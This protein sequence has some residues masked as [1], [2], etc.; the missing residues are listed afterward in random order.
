MQRSYGDEIDVDALN[1]RFGSTKFVVISYRISYEDPCGRGC[2][3]IL[4]RGG[5]DLGVAGVHG[6]ALLVDYLADRVDRDHRA[7]MSN[8]VVISF[9]DL[10]DELGYGTWMRPGPDSIKVLRGSNSHDDDFDLYS[11]LCDLEKHLRTR[12]AEIL[13]ERDTECK[14]RIADSERIGDLEYELARYKRF[15]KQLASAASEGP[16]E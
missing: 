16:Q 13:A 1:A 12:V 14:R 4:K 15:V 2:R 9:D 10:F 7:E 5:S 6:L 3:C 8:L 11:D